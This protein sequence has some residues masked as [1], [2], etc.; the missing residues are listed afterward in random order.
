MSNFLEK[1]QSAPESTKRRWMVVIT[2]VIMVAVIYVWLAYFNSLIAGGFSRTVSLEQ[3]NPPVAGGVSFWQTLKN[4]MA[5][6][7][8]I[9]TGK[10]H[11]LGNVLNAP[12]EYI[13]KPPQ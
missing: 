9:F 4:G 5:N 2:A 3:Q 11:A 10:L 7:Y 6:L 8:E 1:L 13:I 12:R